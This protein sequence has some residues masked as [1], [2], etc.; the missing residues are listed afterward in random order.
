MGWLTVSP[1]T[2][3]R[4]RNF[5]ANRRGYVSLW[6]FLALFA[7]SL[8]AE[9]LANEKPLLISYNG[10]TYVPVLVSYPE[11]TFGGDF[12][13]EADYTDPFV[14]ELIAEKGW[15]LWPPVRFSYDTIIRDLGRPAPAPPS[16]RN[17][18]GTDD[19]ARD[20][21]A[22]VIYGFRIS[23]TFGL[24]LTLFS[25]L[26]GI[27]AGAVQGFYGGW[28]DLGFQRFL[29]IWGGLPALYL[30]I[31]LA[32]FFVPSFWLLL[33]IMLLFSWTAL[34]G[35]VRAEFLRAR[36]FDYVRAARALGVSDTTLMFRHLL[37]NAMVATLT[38]LPFILNGAITTLTSL[39]FLGLGLP[40]GSPSLG[41]LLL[42][43]RNNLNAP[44]LG[45]TGFITLAVMLSLLIFVGEAVRD[46]FD[47]RKT[48]EDPAP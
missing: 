19:Q 25:S 9:L 43:G 48:F 46:A 7:L 12:P 21:L 2:R 24:L 13:T 20:V 33:G 22:R 27:F 38:F 34:T 3:R 14:Q 47:P 35:V 11:T 8:C 45:L 29:E 41:E 1:L 17:W 28:I 44:W 37:P 26:V 32:G 40:P 23:V 42:Q 39:D 4:W 30:L 16:A 36:N 10:G 5:R 15:I 31:I 6:I 18:L